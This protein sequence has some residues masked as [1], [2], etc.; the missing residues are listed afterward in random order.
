LLQQI[1][2]CVRAEYDAFEL[3]AVE[4]EA[5]TAAWD[6]DPT[7]Q[8]R[9]EARAAW[10]AA[11]ARWQEAEPMRFGP[12]A[13]S[14]EPGGQDLRDQIYS[15][16]LVNRCKIEEQLVAKAY[17]APGFSTSLVNSRGLG[18]I[19]YLSFYDG[20]DNGCSQFSTINASGSWA[21]LGNE[22]GERKLDYALAAS[23]D[24]VLRAQALRAAWDP[25]RGGFEQQLI[26]AGN[27]SNVFATD[28]D[29]LN[30]VSDGLFYIELELKDQKLAH[31]LGLKDCF[32]PTCPE[33]IESRWARRS[34]DHLRA[35]LLGF[36]R[37]FEGCYADG[38]G[39]GFDDWL[40][41]VGA[42]DIADGMTADLAGARAAVDALSP[43]LEE[44]IVSDPAKVQ[45]VYAAVKKLTD[46]LKT[47]FVTAL[48][49]ELPKTIEGD[50]D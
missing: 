11:I 49:L 25:A 37:V 1:A 5:R 38:A 16:P 27:G 46:A 26:Q 31:P 34:T 9:D 14:T 47:E 7:P 45:V 43:P 41:A 20:N 30:A 42:N 50:N 36:R 33:D 17:A 18:A 13:R 2:A 12:A 39:L 29:A 28:Q 23:N 6:A 44:A 19:E 10:V 48:N 35:N 24:L 15:W 8:K 40:R 22:L 21:A 4:L 32:T 3:T